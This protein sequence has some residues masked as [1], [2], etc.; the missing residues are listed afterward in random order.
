MALKLLSES[1]HLSYKTFTGCHKFGAFCIFTEE[2]FSML[3]QSSLEMLF[4]KIGLVLL[5]NH[6]RM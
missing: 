4:T 3:Y 2:K 5:L 1:E 6:V